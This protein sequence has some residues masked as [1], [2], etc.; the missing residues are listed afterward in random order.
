MTVIPVP[1]ELQLRVSS[2]ESE[3]RERSAQV[4]ALT[5]QLEQ[6]Q[7]EKRQ[8]EQ[9]VASINSLLEAS[10][11]KKEEDSNQVRHFC[12]QRLLGSFANWSHD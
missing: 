11:N 6:T 8:L 5:V 10:Q 7:G 4:D 1:A 3:V 12:L 2:M 9:Q